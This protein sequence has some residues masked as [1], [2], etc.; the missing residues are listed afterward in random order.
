MNGLNL[1]MYC[2]MKAP[3]RDGLPTIRDIMPFISF[4][5]FCGNGTN[6][7]IDISEYNANVRKTINRIWAAE[8]DANV[9]TSNEYEIGTM[10]LKPGYKY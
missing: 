10:F 1:Y 4:T 9:E 8:V 6:G 5:T 2:K 3:R 7:R